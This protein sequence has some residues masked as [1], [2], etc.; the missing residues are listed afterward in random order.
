MTTITV[1]LL[2]GFLSTQQVS[3]LSVHCI[4]K[5]PAPGTLELSCA[6]LH[7]PPGT[8]PKVVKYVQAEPIKIDSVPVG[9]LAQAWCAGVT[10][11]FTFDSKAI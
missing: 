2:S 6:L 3:E 11:V 7:S 10:S 8:D 9:D 5:Q 1:A 4:A